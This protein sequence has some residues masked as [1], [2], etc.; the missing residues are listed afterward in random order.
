MAIYR[1]VRDKDELLVLLLDQLAAEL[2]RPQLGSDPRERLYQAC[3]AMHDGLAAHE[4]IVDVL[5]QGDLIAPS[6]LWLVEEIVA[7]LIACGRTEREAVEGYR[8]IWRDTVGELIT[9]RGI[10]RTAALRRVPFVVHVLRTVDPEQLPTLAS[11]APYWAP[12]RDRDS[13]DIG[14]ERSAERPR[15]MSRLPSIRPQPLIAVSDV[16]GRPLVSTGPR[17]QQRARRR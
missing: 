12:A 11:L 8:A 6:I 10:R 5:G 13:Y 7:A 4:W 16:G 9:Q 14:R 3:R 2:P 1:H 17:R 15:L